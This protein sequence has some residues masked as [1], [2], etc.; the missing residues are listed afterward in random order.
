MA[1][2]SAIPTID[3]AI[4]RWVREEDPPR[5]PYPPALEFAALKVAIEALDP[6]VKV[7]QTVHAAYELSA[8]RVA[9]KATKLVPG[10][11]YAE[12]DLHLSGQARLGVVAWESRRTKDEADPTRT[13]EPPVPSERAS[14]LAEKVRGLVRAAGVE[15]VPLA[16]ARR[17]V[18]VTD[19]PLYEGAYYDITVFEVL[20]GMGYPERQR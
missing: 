19:D 12:L 7:H 11:L 8:L 9:A 17:E 20:F 1:S 16:E 3:A 6:D 10:V 5:D 2:Y 15:L 18:R 4:G 14:A 13:E